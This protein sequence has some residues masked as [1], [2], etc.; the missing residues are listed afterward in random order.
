MTASRD[1]IIKRFET[2]IEKGKGLNDTSSKEQFNEED[3][4][5]NQVETLILRIGG[6]KLLLRY[7]NGV[8]KPLVPSSILHKVYG[9]EP[10]K[11]FSFI[12]AIN[13]LVAIK[14]DIELFGDDESEK[15]SK[16][17]RRHFEIEAGIPGVAKAK[18][19]AEEK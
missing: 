4:W 10:E 9:T 14:E 11:F 7:H 1:K 13:F 6:E 2:L 3:L 15:E 8:L 18:W 19:G 12:S 16:K 17:L 5:K